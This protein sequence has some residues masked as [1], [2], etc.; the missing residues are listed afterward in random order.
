MR[1][2]FDCDARRTYSRSEGW[3]DYRP[4]PNAVCYQR[5]SI[6][7]LFNAEAA[8]VGRIRVATLGPHSDPSAIGRLRQC[9]ADGS[10]L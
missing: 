6:E 7:S 1:T 2:T 9:V 3:H 4:R 10:C 5:S 8:A